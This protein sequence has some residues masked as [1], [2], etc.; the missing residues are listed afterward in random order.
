[1]VFEGLGPLQE[2][3]AEAEE[4]F[5]PIPVQIGPRDVEFLPKKRIMLTSIKATTVSI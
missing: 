5:P 2:A 1:M 4:E 3:G